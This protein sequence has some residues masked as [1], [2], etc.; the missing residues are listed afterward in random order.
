MKL[1]GCKP[2]NSWPGQARD[3]TSTE[4]GLFITAGTIEMVWIRTV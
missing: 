2:G 3:R 4:H 1:C